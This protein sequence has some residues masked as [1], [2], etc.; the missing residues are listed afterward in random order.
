MTDTGKETL[1]SLAIALGVVICVGVAVLG[2][3][4]WDGG[5]VLFECGG[6][7]GDYEYSII[8]TKDEG[9]EA[10]VPQLAKALAVTCE[11]LEGGEED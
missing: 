8:V 11:A 6:R 2:F 1:R 9:S 10:P 3:F 5:D 7:E 4:I